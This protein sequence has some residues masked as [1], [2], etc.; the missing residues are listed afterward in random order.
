[1]KLAAVNQFCRRR[2]KAGDR[3][4]PPTTTPTT[5]VITV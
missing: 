3:I 2:P 5:A 4:A 1:V